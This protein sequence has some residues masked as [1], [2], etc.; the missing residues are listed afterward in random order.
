MRAFLWDEHN[1]KVVPPYC[2]FHPRKDFS[3]EDFCQSCPL[4]LL[5]LLCYFQVPQSKCDINENEQSNHLLCF[6]QSSAKIYM[7]I[8]C[9]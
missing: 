4:D 8:I 1:R 3:D 5:R 2:T 7:Q 9:P 6:Q